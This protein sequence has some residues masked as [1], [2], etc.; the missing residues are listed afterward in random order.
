M[1][2]RNPLVMVPGPTP[3][4]RRIQDQMGRETISFNDPHFVADFNA[5]LANLKNLWRCDGIV[6][7]VAGSGTMAMEMGVANITQK[8]DRVL[9]C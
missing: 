8:G 3:V 7:V 9:V 6:F 4:A 2:K 5:L 1:I